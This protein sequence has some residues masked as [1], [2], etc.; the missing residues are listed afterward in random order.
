VY[1]IAAIGV[2][3][4]SINHTQRF[5]L[6]HTDDI[7][8][9]DM[10]PSKDYVATGQVSTVV[11]GYFVCGGE[12]S[13]NGDNEVCFILCCYRLEETQLFMSGML[14]PWKHCLF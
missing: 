13:V 1:H 7:L 9:L 8:C 14:K 12:C 4:N 3:Y 6:S 5:Y 2:V 11:G 10:H